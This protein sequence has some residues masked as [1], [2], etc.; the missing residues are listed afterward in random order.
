[1]TREK[2]NSD[3]RR[4][5]ID[6][7]WPKGQSVNAGFDRDTYLGAEFALSFPSIDD[8]TQEL[9]CLGPGAHLYKIDI[10]RV[11]RHLKI[12]PLDYDLLGLY[13]VDMC[14]LFGS[15]H[16]SQLF[17]HVSDAVRFALHRQGFCCINYIN[18][19][20]GFGTPDVAQKSFD[21]CFNA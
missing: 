3:K 11:F 8:I 20:I 16:G 10:S 18:D 13:W 4:V 15:R 12:D 14:L 21:L 1:M 19:F 7:S 2:P 17:Q 5:I 6:L 9:K